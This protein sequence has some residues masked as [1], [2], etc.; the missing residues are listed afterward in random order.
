MQITA[1]DTLSLAL[2]QASLLE[3]FTATKTRG[4]ALAVVISAAVVDLLESVR[5]RK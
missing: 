3:I 1:S 4:R 2:W 5:V